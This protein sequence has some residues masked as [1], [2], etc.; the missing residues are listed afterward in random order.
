MTQ[1]MQ[2]LMDLKSVV[3]ATTLSRATVYRGIRAGTFPKS[4]QIGQRRV[5]WRESD[6]LSWLANR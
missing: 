2:K 1:Q 6:V 4:V 5:A 3:A